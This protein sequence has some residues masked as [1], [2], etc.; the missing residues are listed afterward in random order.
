MCAT[1]VGWRKTPLKRDYIEA[2]QVLRSGDLKVF[3][4]HQTRPTPRAIGQ[5]DQLIV[6]TD[7]QNHLNPLRGA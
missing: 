4:G 2:S 6:F 7:K 5:S 1:L 3:D